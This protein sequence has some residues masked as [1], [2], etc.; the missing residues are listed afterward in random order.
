MRLSARLSGRV[1]GVLVLVRRAPP[2]PRAVARAL[3][4]AVWHDGVLGRRA[5]YRA[6]DG[7]EVVV[8]LLLRRGGVSNV[9][10]R[11]AR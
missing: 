9:G 11:Q 6:R 3:A 2:F 10:E 8:H 5:A 1:A 4:R 7:G